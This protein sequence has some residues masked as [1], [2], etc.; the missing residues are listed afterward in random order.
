MRKK[1]RCLNVSWYRWSART[2]SVFDLL[3]SKLTVDTTSTHTSEADVAEAIARSGLKATPWSTLPVIERPKSWWFEQRTLLTLVSGVAL[4]IGFLIETFATDELSGV[5]NWLA[6]SLYL[7][8]IAA[9]CGMVAPKAWRSL[10][11]L[12][13]DMNLL[14]TVAV[15]GAI[16]IGEWLEGAAVAFLF[17]L[18][19]LLESW[20]VGRARNAIAKL[21]DLSPPKANLSLGNGDILEVLPSE[22]PI[23]SIVIVRP[24][25]KLPLDGKVIAGSGSINQAS[26]T[27]ESVPVEKNP[28]DRVF[29]GTVNGDSLLEIETTKLAENTVLAQIIRMVGDAQSQ[30]A[31]SEKWVEKFAAIYTPLIMIAALLVLLVPPL[32]F[33]GLW[34]DWLYRSL[35]LLV[36]AC[37][38]ALVNLDSS[39]YRRVAC[40]GGQE[41]SP[42]QRRAF[43]EIPAKLRAIALDKT[44]TLTE[45]KPSVVQIVPMNGHDDVELLTRAG[46]LEQNTTHPLA[47]AI[48][49][50]CHQR[51]L[52]I[53]PAEQFQIIQGKGARGVI[54]AKRTGSDRIAT[55]R[56]ADKRPLKSI[57]NSRRYSQRAARSS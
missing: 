12:R 36:I 16:L 28:G 51:K 21:L 24:G 31:P 50:E 54:K 47:E 18:S 20:S 53:E 38:C 41:W 4:S 22:V 9:G 6:K 30:R 49:A 1:S 26:V 5:W 10:I 39:E 29:A 14:M 46:A 13:P 35:V 3:N 56:N 19:L 17:S 37:P 48:I 33:D 27:G 11:T 8:S 2:R 52:S 23:G 34:S 45:G 15:I 32:L 57:S 25:D 43:V 42:H 40:V 44:G 7:I 55:W